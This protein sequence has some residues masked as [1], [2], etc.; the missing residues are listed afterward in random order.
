MISRMWPGLHGNYVQ[1]D[2]NETNELDGS[3]TFQVLK[4]VK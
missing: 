1:I 4:I 2:L 3:Q